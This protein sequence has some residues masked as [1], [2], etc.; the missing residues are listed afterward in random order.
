MGLLSLIVDIIETLKGVYVKVDDNTSFEKIKAGNVC[1]LEFPQHPT[2]Q[3]IQ[4]ND[5]INSVF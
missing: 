2:K 1:A 4:T 3:I 5:N